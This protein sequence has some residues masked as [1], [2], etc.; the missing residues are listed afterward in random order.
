MLKESK[1]SSL[2]VDLALID[3]SVKGSI[4]AHLV[5]LFILLEVIT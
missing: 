3:T 2:V 4:D 5:V 1:S